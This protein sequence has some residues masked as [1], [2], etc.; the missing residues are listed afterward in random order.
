[1]NNGRR[2]AESGVFLGVFAILLLI[3]TYMPFLSIVSTLFLPVPF[4]LIAER[5]SKEWSLL[6]LLAASL[7]TLIISN[8]MAMPLT[9]M[10]GL[11]G[12]V[13]GQYLQKDGSRLQMY[14]VASLI[15]IFGFIFTYAGSILLF[16]IDIFQDSL[17]LASE[18]LE[19][20]AAVMEAMGQTEQ[21]GTIRESMA[22]MMETL[23]QL[24]PSLFIISGLFVTGLIF[25]FNKPI[26]NRFCRNKLIIGPVRNIQ[27]PKSLLWYYLLTM[28]ISLFVTVDADHFLF[29]AILNIMFCLQLFMLLQGIS[30][31]FYFSHVKK[32]HK[33]VPVTIVVLSFIM[34][35]LPPFI[36]ILG[37]MDLGFNLRDKIGPA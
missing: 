24:L 14:I 27:L 25:L 16:D 29:M 20:S 19:Q 15:C 32:W 2:V 36:R 12:I 1:M 4:I 34:P 21:M 3:S 35:L 5:N 6:F 8:L 22:R 23:Q 31:I 28:V 10:F 17:N 26:I 30:L 18:S 7:L 37:I 33:A 11:I 13:M 9:I